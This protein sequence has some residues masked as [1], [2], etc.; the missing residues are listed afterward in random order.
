[1]T[2]ALYDR[3]PPGEADSDELLGRFLDYVAAK[4]LTLYPAQEEAI[5]ELFE[6]KNVILNTPTGSGKSLVASALHFASLAH[7]RRSV[8]T[9]PIKALVNE[10]WMALCREL[11]PEN[12][13]LSTGD[14]TVNREAPVLCCTAEVLANMALRDGADA[15]VDDVVMDEFHWYADRD[16]GVA[17]QVPLLTLP[18]T[19]FLLMSATLGDVAFFAE[20][21]TRGNGRPTATVKSVERP[22]PLEYAYSEIPL[23]QTLEKLVSEDKA[24]VYVVHFTQKDAAD[25]AQDFTS[26]N[27]CTREEKNAV[28]AAISGFRFTS[29]YGPTVR[30]WLKQAIGVHHAGLLPKYR[31]LV[32]QL[33]QQGL[34]KVICGTD[35]LGV[36][37]NVPIRSVLFTR[38]CKFDGQKTAVLSAR[39]FHQIAG[40]AGRKGFDDRGFVLAQAPEHFIENRKLE[41]KAKEGK[42]VVKRKAPEHNFANW[43][44]QTFK[45]LIG[46]PPER[47][48][49]RFQVSHGMLLNVLGRRGDGCRAMQQLIHDSHEPERL[50]GAHFQRAW[51]LFRSLLARAIV[52]ITPRTETGSRL[53]VNVDL[54][55]DFSM[56]QVL[57]LYLL[58]TIPLLEPESETYALDVLTLV[59]SIL[60]N[61]DTILRRQL[62]KLKGKKVAEMKAEGMDYDQRM[63]ELEK[64]EYPKPLAD[65]VYLT[66]NA[67]A[68]RHPWVGEENIRPKSIAREMFE[69]FRSFSDYV[70][71]YDLERSEGL[72]LRHLNSVY[73]VMSQTVP[74]GIKTGDVLEMELYL[75]DMLRQVDSSLLEEWERMRDPSYRPRG[76]ADAELRPAR[77]EQPPDVTRDAK[78]FTA[79]IRTRAFALLRAWSVGDDEAA[80]GALDS[81]SDGVNE[82]WT[83]ERL[84]AAREAYRLEHQALRL[85]PEARNLRHTVVKPADDG[86]AWRVEQMLVD[87]EGLND[88]VAELSVDLAASRLRGEPVLQ[89]LRLGGLV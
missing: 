5:L 32:E 44:L 30:K 88:W 62:D 69:G 39:D 60:E 34:L 28:A 63:A 85:D 2:A 82:P 65:F 57:S 1:M 20:E 74:D 87:A 43:D 66:F 81:E 79:A 55:D 83:P 84:R 53:R 37:I 23:A 48:G 76:A 52:E 41:E 33:A 54:Q 13:G 70:Q 49:S 35:T 42:K 8:Y 7:G 16:R 86:T 67:F 75:R 21:L 40:R 4:G 61:P 77:P 45:R 68:D 47:L 27:L 11:G 24:P 9:C 15:A 25:S 73:K 31:V 10:K 18:H 14:A 56:N 59:E 89:L 80:L 38:L 22:V 71:E 3:L 17:W 58:E 50:K 36:G 29:P 26:L 78:T 12:V 72:L 51:Q 19:R 64:L 6:G 46:A